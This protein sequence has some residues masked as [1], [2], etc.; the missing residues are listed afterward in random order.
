MGVLS[1][2][3]R[4]KSGLSKAK[5]ETG[6]WV[7]YQALL[8]SVLAD[9]HIDP[10]EAESVLQAVGRSFDDLS[11]DAEV[12]R[13]R[14][15][16]RASID[17]VGDSRAE[18]SK[19]SKRVEELTAERQAYLAKVAAELQALKA[20]ESHL[21]YTINASVAA[22][23][24]LRSSVQD[25]AVIYGLEQ[26]TNRVRELV[27]K[28]Q[29]LIELTTLSSSPDSI[30]GKLSL[31]RSKLREWKSKPPNNGEAL[32]YIR[33]QIDGLEKQEAAWEARLEETERELRAVRA[34][35]LQAQREQAEADRR[36]LQP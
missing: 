6:R 1:F 33:R 14:L 23:S 26:A 21:S 7:D 2:V 5:A 9:E 24:D 18:L 22:E 32:E 34:E 15:E 29:R 10:F 13:K 20:K 36:T 17:A 11:I 31:I 8:R 3:E 16:A 19:V 27:A 28:E 35:M 25:P 12:F 4:L 30:P